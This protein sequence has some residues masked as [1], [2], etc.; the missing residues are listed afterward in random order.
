MQKFDLVVV[1]AGSGL[2]VVAEAASRNLRVA[3]VEEGPMG[4][5]CLNRG[6]IPSKMLVHHADIAETIANAKKFGFT[7]KIA[8]IDFRKIVKEVSSVVDSEAREIEEGVREDENTVL[9]KQ[10]AEFVGDRILKVGKE[11]IFGEKVVIAAGTRPSIPPIDGL[12]GTGFLT[13]DEAL[14]L[15]KQPKSMIIVGG[16]YIA[17]EL[18]HFFG[19]LG[20]KVTIVQRN[21]LLVPDEDEEIAAAFTKI[22][23]KKHKVFLEHVVSRVKKRGK[24]FVATIEKKGGSGKKTIEAGQLLIATGRVPNTDTLKVESTG[25]ETTKAG[26]VRVNEFLETTAKNVWALGDVAGIF[27]FKH[28]ANLE[29]SYVIYNMFNPDAKKAVDYTAMPHAVFSAPQIAGVGATEQELKAKGV[30]Y[31]VGKHYFIKTGMGRALK[32]DTGFVKLLAD[33]QTGKILG[34][35]IMGTDASTLIHEVIVAMKAA[36]ARISA[37]TDSVHI[38]P[39]L[40]EVVQRAFSRIEW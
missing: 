28:S 38:H 24:G 31:A 20:T 1:G 6:C 15:E 23:A 33:K 19:A 40:S 14:R 16:G 34:C 17:A 9:F 36:G 11:K 18:A 29:A 7:A 35:H 22:F 21:R 4:G 13:S 12:Q 27:L 2:N 39:A 32:D 3:L 25:V 8:G 10:R 26:F 5:T 30:D 37:I